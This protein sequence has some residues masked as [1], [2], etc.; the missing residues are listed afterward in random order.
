MKGTKYDT[1]K[2][3]WDLLPI[4]EVEEV[5]KVLTLGADKY[6]D[7]NW[8]KVDGTRYYS[9]AMRH[10]CSWRKG[11]LIDEESGC[12]H[13]SHAVCCLLFLMWKDNN[14]N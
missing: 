4:E 7:W 1:D 3:R 11:E 9:A 13:L 12:S 6:E 14:D 2:P 8:T 5:V 10:L